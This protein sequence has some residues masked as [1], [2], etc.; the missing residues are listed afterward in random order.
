M[1]KFESQIILDILDKYQT[2]SSLGS[3]VSLA[4]WDLN[5]YLPPKGAED[6]GFILS[7]VNILLKKLIL[8][9]DLV[10]LI[11]K[12]EKSEQLNDY[13]RA[14]I[15]ILNRE[16]NMIK[17]I[18]DD[19]LEEWN[20]TVNQAQM[21]WREAKEN[22]DFNTF[23]PYLEKIINLTRKRADLLGYDNHP[24]DALID[25]FEEGWNTAD[26][27]SFFF[28]IKNS[29]LEFLE[30]I[31]S[32]KFFVE[33]HP[34][35]N[36][37][38]RQAD[39]EKLNYFVLELLGFDPS[40]SRLDIA[41]HP[42]ENAISYNDV[43]ITTWYHQQDFRKSLTATIHEFGH[44][45][46]E[47]QVD[48]DLK[49]TPLQGGVSYAFHES[50]SRFWENIV[51]RNKVFLERVYDEAR[52]IFPFM[53]KYSFESFFGYLNMI[54]PELIR[55]ESDEITYHFHI[56]LRFELEKALIEGKL[57]ASQLPD[58]WRAK[59]KEYLGIEPQADSDGVLQDIHWSMGAIGYFPTYSLGSFLSG[60]WWSKIE[61]D[62]G[63]FDDI[64]KSN[65]G[66][67]F[68]RDWLKDNIHQYG[69]TYLSKDLILKVYGQNFSSYPFLDY[70][71]LKY[72]DTIGN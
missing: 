23:L 7:K 67:K 35:E 22:D 65:D 36:E 46:Y 41:P 62:I 52:K 26:F 48:P 3:L 58:I 14:V 20:R 13:E 29:L 42:F 69:K 60:L 17:K 4:D 37:K 5:T 15:R 44:A 10:S 54:R 61:R 34:L 55:V 45:L 71:K 8:D 64:L 49:F 68:I 32:S 43:R 63:N 33:K 59:M 56:I 6:R 38:Y 47:L 50:Q 66:L 40:R 25:I 70:L 39:M 18:P 28:R 19:F 53:K 16:I 51:G 24:Y 27:D 2:I 12:A 21:V 11:E 31:K 57:K 30:K 9:G 72:F 1:T